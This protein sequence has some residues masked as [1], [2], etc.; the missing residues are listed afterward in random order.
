MQEKESSINAIREFNRFYTRLIGLLDGH[1]LDS[2]Y[3][4]PEAR[5]LYE[6]HAGAPVS[7]SQIVAILAIDKGY[8]SRI[9]K[10]FE[11]NGLISKGENFQDGRISLLS[12]SKKGEEVFQTL[13]RASSAQVATLLAPLSPEKRLALVRH[14]GAIKEILES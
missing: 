1:L 9:L 2:D 6:I 12:L 11:K 10:K 5:I 8:L 7:A 3:S 13:N 4:L 14:M